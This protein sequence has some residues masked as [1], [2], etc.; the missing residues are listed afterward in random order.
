[1]LPCGGADRVEQLNTA[2]GRYIYAAGSGSWRQYLRD[3]L[4]I[5]SAGKAF[6]GRL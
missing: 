2:S 1:L 4:T 5:A 3:E 6:L